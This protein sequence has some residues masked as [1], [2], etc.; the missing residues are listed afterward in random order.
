MGRPSI[1]TQ[2]ITD[3]IC[4]RMA[5][6][7]SLR[8]ICRDDTMPAL[9]TVFRWVAN[10][11][12]FRE[13]YEAAMAQRA[14][15]LFEELFEIADESCD[16]TYVDENGNTK[17]NAEVIARSR[18]RVDVRKWALS[19]MLPKKYGDKQEIDLNVTDALAERL[20]RA[21]LRN[22]AAVKRSGPDTSALAGTPAERLETA[23]ATAEA[24]A[25]EATIDT[26]AER[27]ARA[28]KRNE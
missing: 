17:T 18:L 3:E 14:E 21:K 26:L 16:D 1:F 10:D 20:A 19:K 5:E 2:A 27:L 24:T 6:G 15:A 13:Q 12:A 9:G 28:R 4:S 8:S 25:G 23:V 11:K 22:D 7:E